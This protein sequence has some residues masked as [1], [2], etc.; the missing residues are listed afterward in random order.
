[1]PETSV[2]LDSCVPR[3]VELAAE[4]FGEHGEFIRSAIRYHVKNESQ[5]ED[6][7][8]DLFLFFV[9]KPIPADVRN[10]KGFLYKVIHDSVR[11]AYRRTERYRARLRRYSDPLQQLTDNRPEAPLMETEE[12]MKMFEL[13]EKRLPPKEALAVTLRYGS[14][15]STGE[16]AKQ[17]GVKPRSVSRYVSVGIKKFRTYL[18]A[19]A[20]SEL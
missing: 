13:I 19:K 15:C 18:E 8:Q 6:L 3:N 14:N 5:V 17:M 11:D 10:V 2:N 16:V 9:S 7:F 20:G 1:M 12:T 4:V